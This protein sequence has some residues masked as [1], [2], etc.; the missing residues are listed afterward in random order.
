[1][2]VPT[3]DSHLRAHWIV[4]PADSW[5]GYRCIP[6]STDVVMS[7][8]LDSIYITASND[9]AFFLANRMRDIFCD[10]WPRVKVTGI[11]MA[12]DVQSSSGFITLANV[13]ED[14]FNVL[15]STA[16]YDPLSGWT[17]AFFCTWPLT[18][19]YLREPDTLLETVLNA[20]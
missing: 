10:G 11:W 5:H 7:F 8:K 13:G 15:R 14:W 16:S 19:S 2:R 3:E 20:R 6:R 18:D 17:D 1:M 9:F 12:V 4:E